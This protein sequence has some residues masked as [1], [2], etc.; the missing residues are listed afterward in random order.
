MR[1]ELSSSQEAVKKEPA[2]PPAVIALN[3]AEFARFFP[4][5]ARARLEA[6]LPGLRAWPSELGGEAWAEWLR[7]EKIEIV[8]S[9]W[10]TPRLPEEPG[11]LRAVCH[12]AGSVRGL[13]PRSLLERGVVVSNWGDLPGRTVAE[14]AL[15]LVLCALRR[16]PHYVKLVANDSRAWSA[17]PHG[18]R[19]L[20]GR[21]VG[22]HGFGSVAR[23]LVPLL[24][25]FGVEIAAY[26]EGVSAEDYAA[27]GVRH[28]DSLDVLFSNSEILIEA[29]GLTPA[30][31]GSV[32]ERRL[33]LLPEGAVFVNV[34]RGGLVADEAALA[35]VAAERG[36][37]LGLDVYREEPLP[38]ESPLRGLDEA[39]L[40]P[41]LAGPTDDEALRAGERLMENLAR[42]LAGQPPVHVV[43][44]AAYDRAT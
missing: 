32:D 42:V 34:A 1:A 20:F 37:R 38:P 40:Q 28:A 21:R 43:S 9:G 39:F 22:I 15:H 44:L 25:P 19:T 24:R 26:S 6:M 18:T 7:A 2:P 31:A 35:R 27:F 36:L 30:T 11:A 14:A 10:V 17:L 3:E 41:H 29:E 16:T 5:E 23:A 12:V 4:G 13:V 33:R 8:V